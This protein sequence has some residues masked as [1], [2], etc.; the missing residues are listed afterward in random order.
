MLIP[1]CWG[2]I[3]LV[4]LLIIVPFLRGKADLIT[5]KNLFLLS[6]ANYIGV[7]GLYAGYLPN[8]F[9]VLDYQRQD[10]E[11]YILGAITFVAT[12]LLS[13]GLI[14]FPRKMA[15]RTLR[16]WPPLTSGVLY[17]M[18]AAS[19]VF[20]IL[21]R[22]PPPIVG[23]AQMFMQLG[24]KAIVLSVALAFAAWFKNRKNVVGLAVFAGVLLFALL[25]AI[26]AGGGRRTLLGV[27]ACGPI[28]WYWFSLRYKHWFVNTALIGVAGALVFMFLLAYT[29]VRHFD[30]R[31]DKE[32]RTFTT[33]TQALGNMQASNI[34]L[35]TLQS[36][37]GQ[38]A[39]Q[40]SLAAIHLYTGPMEPEPF[41]NVIYV[42][43][44]WIPRSL[45]PSKPLGLGYTLPKS[46]KARGTRAT[47]GPGIVGHGFHEG[48]LHMLIFYGL[49]TGLLI[50]YFDELLVRQ[51]QNPYLLACFSAMSGHVFGWCRGD[52]GTFTIQII[53][54]VL[55]MLLVMVV[56]RLAFG[57][58]TVYPRTD[59]LAYTNAN[60]SAFRLKRS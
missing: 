16:K 57:T 46:A 15:G 21:G 11:N 10:Y 42:G 8:V 54:A 55:V 32:E 49:V 27:A 5:L 18:L 31:G 9:R 24:N 25:L 7:A 2:L 4:M 45:W 22:Y 35:A 19:L 58:G 44:N 12:F 48:G 39:G 13:Y 50:R 29:Q 38:N 34:D 59:G 20:A 43:T 1:F 30:R 28:C 37:L 6:I 40:I 47:W 14:K 36:M 51:P 56:G 41:H 60:L 17:S 53:G 26:I 23:I 52:I 3:V 33:A